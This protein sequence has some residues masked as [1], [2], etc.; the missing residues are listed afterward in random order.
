MPDK[1][2]NVEHL[3]VPWYQNPGKALND[4]QQERSRQ[5][6]EQVAQNEAARQNLLHT[7]DTSKSAYDLNKQYGWDAATLK[8]M[9]TDETLSMDRRGKAVEMMLMRIGPESYKEAFVRQRYQYDAIAWTDYQRSLTEIVLMGDP[10]LFAQLSDSKD[11]LPSGRYPATEFMNMLLREGGTQ[12]GYEPRQ[13]VEKW[14][15]MMDPETRGRALY[16]VADAAGTNDI[17]KHARIT[18]FEVG[19]EPISVGGQW[20]YA[21]DTHWQQAGRDI[22]GQLA[23]DLKKHPEEMAAFREGWTKAHDATNIEVSKDAFK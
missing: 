22:E 8:S 21:K 3:Q 2:A 1:P 15:G 14:M 17:G 20:E 10:K 13:G 7:F 16:H 9:A 12:G 11:Q 23:G 5:F 4:W 18:G 19:V 6:A